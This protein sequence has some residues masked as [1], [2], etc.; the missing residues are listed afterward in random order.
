[1]AEGGGSS[2]PRI[3][4]QARARAT[5][6][7]VFDAAMAE[8]ERVGVDAARVEDIV[9]TAGVSWGTFFHW[10]PRKQDVLLEASAE[11]CI[12]FA[13]AIDDAIRG[14]D[15]LPEAVGSAF[16]SIVHAA[17]PSTRLRAAV[18][19]EIDTNPGAL[20]DYLDGRAPTFVPAMARLI[21]EGQYRGEVRD[22]EPAE[23]L[24][25]ILVYGVLGAARRARAGPAFPTS[26]PP[27]VLAQ[28]IILTGLRPTAR[29]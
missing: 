1:M 14:G 10:F 23:S 28:E 11:I 5:R 2:S 19:H 13:A 6:Q 25:A 15:P 29:S 7:R 27:F 9:A 3:P 12:A 24:A 17:P 22:D 26:T 20:T 16:D 4:R 21:G 8:F 18:F